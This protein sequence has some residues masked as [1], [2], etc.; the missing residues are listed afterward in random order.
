[1]MVK[2]PA[3]TNTKP[4]IIALMKIIPYIHPTYPPPK[5]VYKYPFAKKIINDHIIPKKIIG[6]PALRF[7]KLSETKITTHLY[8]P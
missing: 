2:I 5:Y 6:I 3:P 7:F 8:L 4:A 1:M